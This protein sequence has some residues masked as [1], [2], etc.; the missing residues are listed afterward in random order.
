MEQSEKYYTDGLKAYHE[1]RLAEAI[2]KWKNA[3]KLTPENEEIQ[4]SL[5]NAERELKLQGEMESEVKKWYNKGMQYFLEENYDRAIEE[6][7]KI[8][9]M[10]PQHQQAKEMIKKCNAKK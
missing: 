3:L 8:L 7:E 1:G 4:T 10:N 2:E 6:F 9:E 5:R